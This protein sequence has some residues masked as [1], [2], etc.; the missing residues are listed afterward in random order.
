MISTSFSKK[1]C[2]TIPSC[3]ECGLSVTFLQK[4]HVCGNCKKISCES[5]SE[6]F[7]QQTRLKCP[8]CAK[9]WI[10]DTTSQNREQTKH[11]PHQ[12]F[13]NTQMSHN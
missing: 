13:Q 6:K 4:R 8:F 11:Q 5:C 2:Y 7:Y 10:D 9:Q 3:C 12:W 1:V